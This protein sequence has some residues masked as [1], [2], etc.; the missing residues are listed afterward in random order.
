[1]NIEVFN[2]GT[3]QDIRTFLL[4]GLTIKTKKKKLKTEKTTDIMSIKETPFLSPCC[5]E[6]I[7][8]IRGLFTCGN[9]YRT[10]VI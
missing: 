5:E 3:L 9:C 8:I 2:N 4:S 6:N 10:F 7:Y 1:M